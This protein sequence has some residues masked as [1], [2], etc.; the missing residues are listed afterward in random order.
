MLIYNFRPCSVVL[1]ASPNKLFTDFL[2]PSSNIVWLLFKV[3]FYKLLSVHCN[4]KLYIIFY[5]VGSLDLL[6]S[7][8]PVYAWNFNNKSWDK[9]CWNK[10]VQ[11]T[12]WN[13]AERKTICCWASRGRGSNLGN[14]ADQLPGHQLR[15]LGRRS[16]RMAAASSPGSTCIAPSTGPWWDP[17]L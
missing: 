3:I 6:W 8:I 9:H 12:D 15:I 11:S 4:L 10:K 7:T 14:F 1:L 13:T 5:S 17:C 16:R 2:F